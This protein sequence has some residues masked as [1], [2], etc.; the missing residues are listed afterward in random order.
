MKKIIIIEPGSS[1]LYIIKAVKIL[2]YI[3]IIFCSINEY[4]GDQKSFLEK[5]GYYEVN[6]STVDNIINCIQQNK[7]GDI[8]GIISTADRFITQACKA[9]ML[10]GVKGM[11]PSLLKLN[12]KAEVIRLIAEDSPPSIIFNR[13][14]IPYHDLN[15]MLKVS[16]ALVFKP[17]MSAGAKGLFEIKKE[18][19]INNIGEL[20]RKEKQV[21]VIDQ[22]WV[23]QPVIDGILY[24]LEG[25]VTNGKINTIGMS[26]RMR[27][28]YTES[29][30]IFPVDERNPEV[31][32]IL[33]R[34]V[35]DLIKTSGYKNGYL[36]SE[37]IFDG[38]KAFLIDA[39]FGRIGGASV[40]LQV[41][42]ATGKKVEEIY[43]HVI[44]VTFFGDKEYHS[45]FYPKEKSNT[46]SIYYSVNKDATFLKLNL[47][48]N[49]KSDHVQ[50]VDPGKRLKPAGNDNRSW[51]GILTGKP[52]DVT[53]EID[54]I[55]VL[56]D[57]GP[58]KPVF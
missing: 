53:R 36:H 50:V 57:C 6:A 54:L 11:D 25:F 21:N 22:D 14:S 35:E 34:I 18:E 42:L 43:A 52:D 38:K 30:N 40:A 20:M 51:V 13:T 19:E 9:A 3:P 16:N 46:L 33:K 26:Q 23:A 37:A 55:S 44:D 56:T 45:Q 8:L 24:S 2:G 48:E 28:K 4:A 47:P 32:L 58:L 27:I 17:S 39:N 1:M 10:L 15:N 29:Q 12:N 49:I 31:F 5:Q 7:I 41:A